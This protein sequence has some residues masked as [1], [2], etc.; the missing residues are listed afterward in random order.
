LCNKGGNIC[1]IIYTECII[2]VRQ[3]GRRI[4]AIKI[5]GIIVWAFGVI[6]AFAQGFNI[7]HIAKNEQATEHIC[8]L[9]ALLAAVTV[10][11]KV[12]HLIRFF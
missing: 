1:F 11:I 3:D 7:R 4:M 10:I 8:E 12:L 2:I 9:Q 5:I 6:W